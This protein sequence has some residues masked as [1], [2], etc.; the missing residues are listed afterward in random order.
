MPGKFQ[1]YYD[2]TGEYRFRLRDDEDHI[3]LVSESYKQKTSAIK[4]IESIRSNAVV[5]KHYE[6][7]TSSNDMFMFNLKAGNGQVIGTSKLYRTEALRG[8]VIEQV[9]N[10]A[11]VASVDDCAILS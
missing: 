10:L 3:I 9:R 8:K 5:D 1:I 11:P 6:L 2:K 4:G 7:K